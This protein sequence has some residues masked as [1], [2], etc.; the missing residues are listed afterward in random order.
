MD[1]SEKKIFSDSNKIISKLQLLSTFF[2]EEVIYKIFVRSQVIHKLFESNP[3]IDTY[4]LS[5]FHL[6][7]TES[8]IELLRR[9][10]KTN[11]KNASLI[12]DEIALNNDLI[13]KLSNA[14]KAEVSID[15]EQKRHTTKVNL[16]LRNLYNNLSDLS[17]DYPFRNTQKFALSF[18]K[19]HFAEIS[20]KLFEELSVFD[21]IKVYQN[22]YAV[23]D[24]KLMGLQCRNQ[25]NNAFYIGL[26]SGT[27]FLEV[28]KVIEEVEEDFYFTFDPNSNRF[29]ICDF[30]KIKDIEPIQAISKKEKVVHELHAKN[31]ELSFSVSAIKTKIPEDVKKLLEEYYNKIKGMDFL[32]FIDDLD[33]QANI[34]K[35]MLDTKTM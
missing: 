15:A 30:S 26:K 18:A 33:V 21:P 25:F 35:V 29:L 9:I 23:I 19:D 14:I 2:E 6:Q 31:R 10:K 16:A 7:F 17:T 32:D 27:R 11:E 8:V 5:L 24:K 34:L 4:K 1:E 13:E 28:F 3:E 22:D 20:P 12:L